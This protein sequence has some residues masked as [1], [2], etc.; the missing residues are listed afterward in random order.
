M[1]IKV[2]TVAQWMAELL[3][4]NIVSYMAV[5]GDLYRLKRIQAFNGRLSPTFAVL[6]RTQVNKRPPTLFG[7]FTRDD[8]DC[9]LQST[10][11]L[12]EQNL[13][14]APVEMLEIDYG[15]GMLQTLPNGSVILTGVQN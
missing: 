9:T 6:L 15:V 1:K 12:S 2:V 3:P 8:I 11:F 5:E 10:V 4:K 14:G 13:A 7:E